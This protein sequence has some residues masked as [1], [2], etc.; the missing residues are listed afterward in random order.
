MR[1]TWT[2]NYHKS[3]DISISKKYYILWIDAFIVRHF[4]DRTF[5]CWVKN[6]RRWK[7]DRVFSCLMSCCFHYMTSVPVWKWT[8]YIKKCD[9]SR[10]KFKPSKGFENVEPNSWN[11]NTKTFL[12]RKWNQLLKSFWKI[13]NLAVKR[14]SFVKRV[15]PAVEG[16]KDYLKYLIPVGEWKNL[17]LKKFL[18]KSWFFFINFWLQLIFC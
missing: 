9:F 18:T 11:T 17:K 4:L 2:I 8:Y 6:L 15:K 10:K 7:Q 12:W 1:N 5:W 3:T 13:W 16:K 14:K